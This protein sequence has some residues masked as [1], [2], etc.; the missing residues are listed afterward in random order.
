MRLVLNENKKR[1]IKIIHFFRNDT[2]LNASESSS[3]SV[4]NESTTVATNENFSVDLSKLKSLIKFKYTP[5]KSVKG[6]FHRIFG[7]RVKM[8][9]TTN[10]TIMT[11]TSTTLM[12]KLITKLNAENK[13][14]EISNRISFISL[15]EIFNCKMLSIN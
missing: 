13:S 9:N 12:L 11:T 4:N 14:A 2:L 7:N 6:E 8:A 1:K 3:I 15:G 10:S 5:S